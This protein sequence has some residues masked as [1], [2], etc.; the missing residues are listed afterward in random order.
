LPEAAKF[1]A[2]SGQVTDGF[3]DFIKDFRGF[4][5]KS[6]RISAERP[7]PQV[8]AQLFNRGRFAKD[9]RGFRRKSP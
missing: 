3:L 8:G 6:Q 7:K 4:R 9:F 5:R 2:A 1:L